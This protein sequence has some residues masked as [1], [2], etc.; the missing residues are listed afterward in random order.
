MLDEAHFDA[1]ISKIYRICFVKKIG[2]GGGNRTRVQ[3]TL[4]IT[5]TCVVSDFRRETGLSGLCKAGEN[6]V[7]FLLGEPDSS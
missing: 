6:P 7:V 2:G 5:S 3:S 1:M 4:K